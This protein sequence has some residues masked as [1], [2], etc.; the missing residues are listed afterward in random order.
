MAPAQRPLNYTRG[1]QP[2]ELLM[3]LAKKF[4]AMRANVAY[5]S[6]GNTNA[7][8]PTCAF[9]YA[10]RRLLHERRRLGADA[11]RHAGSWPRRHEPQRPA[12]E[13]GARPCQPAE[14]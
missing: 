6:R 12:L 4:V 11:A 10:A 1:N 8:Q 5:R 14:R 2:R 3:R 9:R 13:T 7:A